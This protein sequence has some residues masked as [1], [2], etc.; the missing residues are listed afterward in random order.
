VGFFFSYQLSA[1]SK[2]EF[3]SIFL[4]PNKGRAVAATVSETLVFA[5]R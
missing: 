3:T 1:V 2:G 5:E 4:P